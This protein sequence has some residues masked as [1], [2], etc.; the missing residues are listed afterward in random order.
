MPYTVAKKGKKYF[1]ENKNTSR[2]MGHHD[3]KE[4]A[5]AQM[6]ALYANSKEGTKDIKVNV[7]ISGGVHKM[8]E[9]QKE[10]DKKAD[11]L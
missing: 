7:H 11:M 5:I 3:T 2:V 8:P 4:K 6:R 1:V 9:S 10:H